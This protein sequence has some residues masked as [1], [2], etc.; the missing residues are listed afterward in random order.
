LQKRVRR[1]PSTLQWIRTSAGTKAAK[2]GRRDAPALG[3]VVTIDNLEGN[4]LTRIQTMGALQMAPKKTSSTKQTSSKISSLA[5]QVLSGSKK[6]TPA[7]VRSLAASAL[8]QD[9]TQGQQPKK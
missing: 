8:A 6:P 4:T 2:L 7:E 3:V 1:P 5:G 9:Q